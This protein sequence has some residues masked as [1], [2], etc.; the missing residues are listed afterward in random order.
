MNSG[1][2]GALAKGGGIFDVMGVASKFAVDHVDT[3]EKIPAIVA[4]GEAFLPLL[5]ARLD[6]IDSKLQT[7]I[8]GPPMVSPETHAIAASWAADDPRNS[9]SDNGGGT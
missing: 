1:L 6:A 7:I 2:L 9:E 3:L 4:R 5:V 8:G